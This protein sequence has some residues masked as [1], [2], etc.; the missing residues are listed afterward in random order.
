MTAVYASVDG[1]SC[2]RAFNCTHQAIDMIFVSLYLSWVIFANKMFDQ[3][4]GYSRWADDDSEI[5]SLWNI[6]FRYT[7]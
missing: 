4:R 2:G 1:G 6:F 5:I 3:R 7:N